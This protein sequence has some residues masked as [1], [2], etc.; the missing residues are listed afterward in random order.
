RWQQRFHY[1]MVDEFQDTNAAQLRMV[2][3][4][5]AVHGNLVVVGD[6]DQSIYSWRGAD[7][8]NILRFAEIFPGAKVVKLEQ[9]Y[10]STK[11]ILAAANE[12]ISNNTKRHG[13]TVWSQLPDGEAITHAVAMTAEDEA[14]WIAREICKLHQEGRRWSD[15]AIMYRSN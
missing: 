1:V 3:Q 5:V 15:V 7:P 4:L 13:K 6:D 14:K 2:Q 8:T 9:N 12:V 11:I 10:R